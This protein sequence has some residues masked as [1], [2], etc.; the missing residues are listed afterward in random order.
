MLRPDA[1]LS[2]AIRKTTSNAVMANPNVPPEQRA[3]I[4]DMVGWDA[5]PLQ[6]RFVVSKFCHSLISYKNNLQAKTI[7]IAV[8]HKHSAMSP[9]VDASTHW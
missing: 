6:T 7:S 1:S 3:A 2:E 9:K 4:W 5:V 8:P